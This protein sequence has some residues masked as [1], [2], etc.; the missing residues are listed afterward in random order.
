MTY[1]EKLDRLRDLG[2][3]QGEMAEKARRYRIQDK[4]ELA[5]RFER[6]SLAAV[7]ART[8]MHAAL[9]A[10]REAIARDGMQ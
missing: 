6:A 7:N 9:M 2:D 5:L 4:P 3:M 10:E 1:Q 8:F